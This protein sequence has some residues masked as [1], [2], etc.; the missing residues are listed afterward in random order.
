[1]STL[2]K[3]ALDQ[4]DAKRERRVLLPVPGSPG[5]SLLFRTVTAGDV[6]FAQKGGKR[7]YPKDDILAAHQANLTLISRCCQEIWQNDEAT[8]NDAGDPVGF[9]DRET[10]EDLGVATA[11]EAVAKVVGR[12]GDVGTLAVALLSESGFDA[13]GQPLEGTENPT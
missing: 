9:G 11:G 10:L 13:D 5:V 7:L 6:A 1:M 3:V 8:L 2:F 12:D 4:A